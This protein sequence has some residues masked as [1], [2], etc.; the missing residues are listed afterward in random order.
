MCVCVVRA[1]C[2]VVIA[3]VV[4]ADWGSDR[5]REGEIRLFHSQS[6]RPSVRAFVRSLRPP[7]RQPG[8]PAVDSHHHGTSVAFLFLLLLLLRLLLPGHAASPVVW[9]DVTSVTDERRCRCARVE[10]GSGGD[11]ILYTRWT[12]WLS[13]SVSESVVVVAVIH[14]YVI[15]SLT[16]DLDSVSQSRG[17]VVLV[18]VLRRERYG[19]RVS[20]DTEYIY[21]YLY[22]FRECGCVFFP[23]GVGVRLSIV[24]QSGAGTGLSVGSVSVFCPHW[25]TSP[26]W[27]LTKDSSVVCVND[28][29]SMLTPTLA[30]ERFLMNVNT[31]I[32]WR[33]VSDECKHQH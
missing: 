23:T 7:A 18:C 30:G 11:G 4:V 25:I 29:I 12:D 8:W 31:N 6:L 17:E 20:V 27:L 9:M 10:R 21:I 15:H 19:V 33:A 28:F 1:R 14:R 13:W 16:A 2:V 24:S 26:L 3:I 5:G 22:L 32:S